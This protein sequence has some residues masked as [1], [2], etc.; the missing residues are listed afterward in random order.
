MI[1][2]KFLQKIAVVSMKIHDKQQQY[3]I[4]SQL[5]KQS[6]LHNKEMGVDK[7]PIADHEVIVSLTTYGKRLYE[8]YLTIESIMAGTVKPNK[9]I[10]WLQNDM[11]EQKLPE[12]IN[13]LIKRGLEVRYTEDIKSY[14]KLVPALKAFP[15]SIIITVD[16]DVLYELDLVENLLRHYKNNPNHVY[17]NR[18]KKIEVKR[19]RVLSYKKWKAVMNGEKTSPLLMCIGVGG[20]LYPPHCFKNEVLNDNVF[21]DVCPRADDIWFWAMANDNG[22]T[23]CKVDTIDKYGCDF[24]TNPNVQDIALTRTNFSGKV[25]NDL[26]FQRLMNKYNF[27]FLKDFIR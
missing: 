13:Q 5:I 17:G 19:N 23:E 14:K 25:E 6:F 20:V 22:Y 12:T 2:N 9:I 7:N 24:L 15:D 26:Q 3:F 18:V 1:I 21:M 16:D 10:L 4:K 11:K 27:G 8:V